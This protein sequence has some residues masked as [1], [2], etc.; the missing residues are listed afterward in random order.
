M[1]HRTT[2]P[3]RCARIS[4]PTVARRAA[5]KLRE[6]HKEQKAKAEKKRDAITVITDKKKNKVKILTD[7]HHRQ[8]GEEDQIHRHR[9]LCRRRLHR[10]SRQSRPHHRQRPL[11]QTPPPAIALA[12]Y[13]IVMIPDPSV[14]SLVPPVSGQRVHGH[15][16]GRGS[17]RRP[18]NRRRT[19]RGG[20]RRPGDRD[21]LRGGLEPTSSTSTRDDGGR[22][23]PPMRAR[24]ARASSRRCGLSV[25]ASRGTSDEKKFCPSAPT[26]LSSF[27]H[28]G[29]VFASLYSR[30]R[31]KTRPNTPRVECIRSRAPCLLNTCY[32]DIFESYSFAHCCALGCGEG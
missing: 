10:G 1:A 16:A 18:E 12:S 2:W 21:G 28:E 15:R 14:D 30:P 5:D 22:E 9:R 7:S 6:R 26:R 31:L 27:V 20:Y 25:R 3:P 8:E 17:H 4:C 23:L 32:E 11:R 24:F 19:S 13:T 29:V